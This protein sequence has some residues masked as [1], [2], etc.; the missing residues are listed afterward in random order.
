MPPVWTQGGANYDTLFGKPTGDRLRGDIDG[1][2]IYDML[3]TGPAMPNGPCTDQTSID[4]RL[5]PVQPQ[6]ELGTGSGFNSD[7]GYQGA[8]AQFLPQPY[9]PISQS[10]ASCVPSSSNL[11]GPFIFNLADI[12][13]DGLADLIL[14]HPIADLPM[15][16]AN[17]QGQLLI[18]T[19]T[20]LPRSA[21][22]DADLPEFCDGRFSSRCLLRRRADPNWSSGATYV[23]LNGDGLVDIA[24]AGSAGT[25]SYIN[26][27]VPPVI[28]SFPAGMALPTQVSYTVI[29]T[30]DA[31]APG[32]DPSFGPIYSDASGM[33]SRVRV[34]SHFLFASC[35]RSH[36]KITAISARRRRRRTTTSL[37][38]SDT[39]GR[40]PVGFMRM[41]VVDHAT[42]TATTSTP[43]PKPIPT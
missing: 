17:T 1:D 31:R 34:R 29:T 35:H 16:T 39:V 42:Q 8:A 6:I 30:A 41:T 15:S 26:T 2:G 33:S 20:D 11:G 19:G 40:G 4:V 23:D 25:A 13:G 10:Y 38:C 28:K 12:N 36:R 37:S 22:S 21:Q 9:S 24:G 7:V 32:L 27:F 43:S 3:L 5:F 18:N 14:S